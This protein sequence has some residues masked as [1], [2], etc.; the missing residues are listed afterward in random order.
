QEWGSHAWSY[1]TESHAARFNHP[2]HLRKRLVAE[3]ARVYL[4]LGFNGPITAIDAA[5]GGT[6]TTYENTEYADEFVIHGR[7][8]YAAVNNEPQ[9][10][11]PGDGV[12]PQRPLDPPPPSEKHVH[13]IDAE[14]GRLLWRSGAF[15]GNP[16]KID[17]MASMRHLNLTVGGEGVFV[18]DEKHVVGL[19]RDTGEEMWRIARALQADPLTQTKTGDLYHLYSNRN[20]HTVVHHDNRLFILHP[21]DKDGM[22]HTGAAV[23]QALDPTTG[24]ELWRYEKATPIAYIEWP[25]LFIVGDTVWLPDKKGMDLVALDAATGAQKRAHSIRKALDVGHHHRCYPNRATVRRL[26]HR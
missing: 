4:T 8:L 15:V 16:S 21:G 20:R 3:G 14:S 5:T 18:V 19:R 13:A 7:V 2:L 9:K 10:P 24:R 6:I 23:L 11:W 12:R 25:D 17:R 26:R 22:K 1:W